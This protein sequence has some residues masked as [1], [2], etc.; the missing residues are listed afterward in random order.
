MADT[1][2]LLVEI[3]CEELPPTA[4]HRLSEAFAAELVAGIDQ[5]GLSHGEVTA[6]ATPRRLAVLVEDLEA[7]QQDREIER[8]G[9]ALKAAYDDD[10]KPTKAAEGFARS[11]GIPVEH[12]E[13]FKNDQGEWLVFRTTEVGER[14][15]SLVP[16]LVQR[17]LDRLPI[18]KRM[19]WADLDVEFV[20]PVHWLVLIYADELIKTSL[21][22]VESGRFTHG[23][24]FHA[25]SPI[26]IDDPASYAM[27]LYS[28][29]HV[30]ASFETRRDMIRRQVTEAA[31]ALG[32]RAVIDEDLLDETV[33]LVEWPTIVAG[34]FEQKYLALPAPVLIATMKGNQRYF[35]VVD[36]DDRL[37]PHFIAVSNIESRTPE[38]VR[39]G[40]ERVIRP[41]LADAAFFYEADLACS[42]DE[43]QQQL[44][45]IVFQQQLGSI[46]DKA[47]RVSRLAGHIAVAMGFTPETMKL[48]RRAGLLCK[49]DLVSAVV[50][51]FP[52]LQG[53]M[54]RVYAAAKGEDEALA[55]AIE[56]S[57][58]PRFAGDAIASSDVGRAVAIA[59]K[60]DTLVG[61]FG[62]GQLPTGDRDPFALRRA[63]LGVLRTIIEA[64]LPVDLGKLVSAAVGNYKELFEAGEVHS[65]VMEFMWERLRSYFLDKGVP[66]DVFAAVHARQPS[67]PYDFALRAR[68]V[69]AFR[70][71]PAAAS[72][73]A[74]NKRIQNILRQAE[75]EVPAEVDDTLFREDAEW[76][77]AA[78]LVGI[79]PRVRDLLKHGDY[80]SAMTSLAGLHE[81]VD[82]FFDT[83]KVMDD[84]VAVRG[85]RL[86]LLNN[87]GGLFLETADISRL[88]G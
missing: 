76:N 20:R 63:A 57:Y 40:N 25:P 49:F 54:G 26:A 52:E 80:T 48:A 88:Q 34:S 22:G 85:N 50:L 21:L 66:A 19:R 33:A 7:S 51:E 72:L 39:T 29:G 81:A 8:R 84:N 86:A 11:V 27:L 35:H 13:Q 38:L 10:G 37:M 4:L 67:R 59:D 36:Q 46:A 75:Q 45:G 12:L 1:G 64:E 62:I 9:P 5:A 41:R 17:A 43:W 44:A 79:G 87:I 61:V 31:T 23:H 73:A 3:G 14:T 18:P 68:A 74:A 56:E 32:G 16:G 60:L 24:R 70:Q 82:A 15:T 2:P 42:I 58:L 28:T 30:V 77:L 55:L 65:Q 53:S 83:V 71:L 69:D 78:K 47:E 6:Y